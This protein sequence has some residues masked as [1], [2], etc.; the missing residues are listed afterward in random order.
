M[1]ILLF[2]FLCLFIKVSHSHAPRR[3]SQWRILS[4]RGGMILKMVTAV[5]P[6]KVASVQDDDKWGDR[7]SS[8]LPTRD[9]RHQK[10]PHYSSLP[11]PYFPLP[12]YLTP[13]ISDKPSLRGRRTLKGSMGL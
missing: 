13:S 12:L 4:V 6:A 8:T 9:T 2:F 1:N 5:S 11:L 7:R 10:C 3:L